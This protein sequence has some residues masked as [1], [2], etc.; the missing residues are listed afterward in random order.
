MGIIKEGVSKFRHTLFSYILKK[1]KKV[2]TFPSLDFVISL[3]ICIFLS[4]TV[5][6]AKRLIYSELNNTKMCCP[7]R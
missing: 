7:T 6:I 5:D 2:Q 1:N 3:K 4:L